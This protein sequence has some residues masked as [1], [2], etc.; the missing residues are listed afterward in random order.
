VIHGAIVTDFCRL[1]NYD[2][3]AMINKKAAANTRPWMDFYTRQKTASLRDQTGYP[4]KSPAPQTVRKTMNPDRMKPRACSND[5]EPMPSG[6]VTV[7]NR[8]H[9]LSHTTKHHPF[10]RRLFHSFLR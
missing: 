4:L 2:T 6:W 10:L 5:F 8:A 7:K 3:H 1:T 9:I